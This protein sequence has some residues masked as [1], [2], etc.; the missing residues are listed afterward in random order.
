MGAVD[1]L[2]GGLDSLMGGSSFAAPSAVMPQN[3]GAPLGGGLGNLFD[4]AGGVGTLSGSY[5]GKLSIL[6]KVLRSAPQE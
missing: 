3:L 6:D 1:L 5:V 2:G 4:L